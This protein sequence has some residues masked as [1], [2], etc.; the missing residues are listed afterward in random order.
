[1]K[2]TS[3]T[4]LA[5]LVSC[6][7]TKSLKQQVENINFKELLNE[8]QGGF[9]TAKLL[10]ITDK[11]GLLDVYNQVNKIRKP[12]FDIPKLDYKKQCLLA[13]FMGERSTGGYT[14]SVDHILESPNKITVYIEEKNPEGMTTMVISSPFCFVLIDKSDKEIVFEK[15]K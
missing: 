7:S 3:F 1:M 4:L 12:N 2:I 10:V 13:L 9:D 14:I 5:I 6:T 15:M 11:Q 8:T